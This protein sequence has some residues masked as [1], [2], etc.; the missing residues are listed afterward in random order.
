[1]ERALRWALIAWVA[2]ALEIPAEASLVSRPALRRKLAEVYAPEI[3]QDRE[4]RYGIASIPFFLLQS[5]LMGK[6]RGCP[7]Q[8]SRRV[9]SARVGRGTWLLVRDRFRWKKHARCDLRYDPFAIAARNE[10][11]QRILPAPSNLYLRLRQR[12]DTTLLRDLYRFGITP[13]VSFRAYERQMHWCR[14]RNWA[15]ICTQ[16]EIRRFYVVQFFVPLMYNDACNIH[17]GEHEGM[18][19]LVDAK[20]FE[21]AKTDSDFRRAVKR[22]GY[23]GHYKT[24]VFDPSQVE[25]VE[26][27]HPVAYM[28]TPGHALYPKPGV[29][30]VSLGFPV[31]VRPWMLRICRKRG[32]AE[33]LNEKHRGDG[34]IYRTWLPPGHPRAIQR[35]TVL[36]TLSSPSKLPPS[37]MPSSSAQ[38][39][40][41]APK[42]A[43]RDWRGLS[44]RGRLGRL[45]RQDLPK[46]RE[47][48]ALHQPPQLAAATTRPSSRM[49]LWPQ[50]EVCC[51]GMAQGES[52]P[53]TKRPTKEPIR[54]TSIPTQ[55][56]PK[57][58]EDLG[59]IPLLPEEEKKLSAIQAL[60][61]RC[62]SP[63]P[64]AGVRLCDV[65]ASSK[66]PVCCLQKNGR[67]FVRWIEF[68]G[69][70]GN[71]EPFASGIAGAAAA[72]LGRVMKR[73]PLARSLGNSGPFGPRWIHQS[74]WFWQDTRRNPPPTPTTWR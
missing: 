47:R 59:L 51:K 57:R 44:L 30:D 33:M 10:G 70:W 67:E 45:F 62:L 24:K 23:Y 50:E 28:G 72:Q 73:W 35:P 29:T 61:A 39:T 42:I 60:S 46:Y 9:P 43:W 66:N 15:M 25:F 4:E 49:A 41:E 71:Q 63:L 19:L 22:V 68:S 37:P 65:E 16:D 56:R 2:F 31:E 53:E 40:K 27:T 52:I 64:Y 20:E 12:D 5:D 13:E 18:V 21:Q 14:K 55:A 54:P 48:E 6:L 7:R 34:A 32:R 36:S 38:P 69:R 3:R 8:D 17:E 1:M 58:L 11:G 74:T 26:G